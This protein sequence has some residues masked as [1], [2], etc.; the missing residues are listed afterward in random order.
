MDI[1]HKLISR[2]DLEGE[3][4]REI[5]MG[6]YKGVQYVRLF[7]GEGKYEFIFEHY[8]PKKTVMYFLPSREENLPEDVM[9][10]MVTEIKKDAFVINKYTSLEG[11]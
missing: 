1:V 2:E 11:K 9:E 6:Q 10:E 4:K 5:K 8:H 7:D 3:D